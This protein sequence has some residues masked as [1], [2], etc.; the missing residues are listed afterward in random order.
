LKLKTLE[1]LDDIKKNK[2]PLKENLMDFKIE[3]ASEENYKD[4]FSV[5]KP[6]NMH[7]VPSV[8][9]EKLDILCFF[10]AKIDNKKL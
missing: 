7:H 5:M 9:V 10:V 2:I 6:W 3:K 8:E 4:I 1:Y